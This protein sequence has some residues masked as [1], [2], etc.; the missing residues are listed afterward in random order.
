MREPKPFFRKQTGTWY[1]QIGKKQH[2]LGPYEQVAKQKYHALMAGR[3]PVTDDTTVYAVLFQFLGWNK[4]HREESTHEFYKRHIVSFAE[5]IGETLTVGALKPFH[6]TSWVNEHY[7]K[8]RKVDGKKVAGVGDNYRRSAI[9]SVQRA[10][11]WAVEQGYLATSPIAKVK[12]PAYKPRDVILT[13]EQWSQLVAALEARGPNGRA[14]LDLLMLMRQTGCRP[15]EARKAEARHFDR[16]NRC[17]VFER[18]E[19]KGHGGDKTV[20]R[21]VV[22]LTD[23]A[24][25]I[26]RR[27]ALKNSTGPLLRNTHGTP[28]TASGMKEWFKRLDARRYKEP[29]STRVGFRMSAYAIRHTWATEA[30][31]NGVDPI[32]VATIMGHKDLTQLM[33]TYQHIEK[34]RDYLRKALHQALGEG[35]RTEAVPA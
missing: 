12:K 23:V 16:K 2:N 5:Q 24:F 15:I 8:S 32:T 10:F 14:F 31:E 28:W 27:Q 21:R 13:P 19:S 18:H 35:K 30:L 6:V 20:E 34:K 29:S 17:L 9:R 1:V 7:S 22:P 25:E 33:K 11:N 26:C 3:Q 4:E